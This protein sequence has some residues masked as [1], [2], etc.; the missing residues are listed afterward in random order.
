THQ[1]QDWLAPQT[2]ELFRST[3]YTTQSFV[4]HFHGHMHE[5][6]GLIIAEAGAPPRRHF[7]GCSL[8]GL[9]HYGDSLDLHRARFGYAAGRLEVNRDRALLYLWPRVGQSQQS[10]DHRLVPDTTASLM[11]GTEHLPPIEIPLRL[12]CGPPPTGAS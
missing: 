12:L 7:Q 11:A 2:Q 3:I 9:E 1:P 6:A 5:P 10:G 4:A 8:F